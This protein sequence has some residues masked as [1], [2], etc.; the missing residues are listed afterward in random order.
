M[1][2]IVVSLEN[3]EVPFLV[4]NIT[5][6]AKNNLWK[7]FKVP[8]QLTFNLAVQNLTPYHKVEIYSLF[9]NGTPKNQPA[10]QFINNVMV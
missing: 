1:C 8:L 3:E 6:I 4:S 10:S 9:T 7:F 5:K 2:S